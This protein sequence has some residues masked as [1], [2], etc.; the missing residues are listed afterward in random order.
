MQMMLGH[1]WTLVLAVSFIQVL[2]ISQRLN[3]ED[4]PRFACKK[5]S[6]GLPSAEIASAVGCNVKLETNQVKPLVPN[7]FSLP[8]LCT[9]DFCRNLRTQVQVPLRSC[10]PIPLQIFVGWMQVSLRLVSLET[11]IPRRR[12]LRMWA[13]Q[14]SSSSYKCSS[15]MGMSL[16][17]IARELRKGEQEGTLHPSLCV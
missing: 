16:L 8:I 17:N 2:V 4:I 12:R 3:L 5:G 6:T 7:R 15:L 10:R 14:P 11:L 1:S 9:C 13:D